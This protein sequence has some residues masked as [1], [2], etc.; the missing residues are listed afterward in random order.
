MKVLILCAGYATRMY[1]LTK[2]RPKALLSVAGKPVIEYIIKNFEKIPAIDTVYIITNAKY[3]VHFQKWKSAF[4]SNKDMRILS[5]NTTS[6]DT[7]LGAIGDIQFAIEEAPID[8]DLLIAA[9]DNLCTFDINDFIQFFEKRGISVAVHNMQDKQELTKYNQVKLDDRCRLIS[10][11]EKP[12]KPRYTLAAICMY[13]FPREKLHFIDEYLHEGNNPD[14]PGRLIQWLYKRED[15]FGYEFSGKW[16]DIGNLEQYRRVNQEC[17]FCIK[18][19][20]D[21]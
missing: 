7:R 12:H 14:E 21:P 3:A 10:F 18:K 9:G 15:V 13:M 19:N 20:T 1:P 16:Y 11:E 17:T 4:S 5:D 6:N 8:D 2:D